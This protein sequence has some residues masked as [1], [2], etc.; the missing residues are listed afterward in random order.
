[1]QISKV[2]TKRLGL[3]TDE[4]GKVSWT[5]DIK[6]DVTRRWSFSNHKDD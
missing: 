2:W 6:I 3:S 1:M 4:E 5:K